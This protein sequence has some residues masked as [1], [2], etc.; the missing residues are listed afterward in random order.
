MLIEET[1]NPTAT[2][3]FTLKIVKQTAFKQAPIQSSELSEDK[4]F[5]VEEVPQDLPVLAYKYENQHYK[6]TFANQTF[7]GFNT[8]YVYKDHVELLDQAGKPIRA[9]YPGSLAERV[10]ACC[11]ERGY[12]LDRG[13]GEINLI[14]I[15][16]MDSDGTPNQDAPNVF[17][18]LIGCLIFENGRARFKGLYVGTTE[19]SR[20]YTI[21]DPQSPKGAARLEFGQQRCWQVG[22]Q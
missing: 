17:N 12:R 15:E 4:L 11:E 8:W 3:P 10:V 9:I 6:V 20:Y 1:R 14:G 22:H 5:V 18:D 7:K 16:G 2:A 19:P 13:T 21:Q